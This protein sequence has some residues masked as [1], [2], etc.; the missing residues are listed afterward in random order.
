ML[1][2]Y[3]H[4]AAHRFV[5]LPAG[6]LDKPGEDPLEAARRELLEEAG[7]EAERVAAPDHRAQLAG[8]HLRAHRV[9]LARGPP[10]RATAAASGRSTRRPT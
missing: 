8:V 3:R 7:L 1:R 6:L 2:Q 4:A 5:E 10:A 9:F